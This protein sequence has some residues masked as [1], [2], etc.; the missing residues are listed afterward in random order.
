M[1]TFVRVCTVLEEP[2]GT[3]GIVQGISAR[4]LLVCVSLLE[5]G[6]EVA[7]ANGGGF[8]REIGLLISNPWLNKARRTSRVLV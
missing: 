3:S 2:V 6:R 8:M 7:Y 1:T 4:N 5:S